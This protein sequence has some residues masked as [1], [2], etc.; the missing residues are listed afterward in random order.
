[1]ATLT[2]DL[3]KSLNDAVAQIRYALTFLSED[4]VSYDIDE[5][6]QKIRIDFRPGADVEEMR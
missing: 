5:I 2:V 3:D 6:E 4:V 1:M